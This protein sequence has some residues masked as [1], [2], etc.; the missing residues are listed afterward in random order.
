MNK[1]RLGDVAEVILSNIDKK[2]V[3]GQAK[4]RLCNFT[5]VYYNW[6]ITQE[7]HES[8][9]KATATNSQIDSLSISKGMVAITKDSETKYDIG[10]SVYIADDFDDVVLGYHCVLIKPNKDLLSGKY[11]NVILHSSYAQ[12]YFENHASGSG[13]RYTL[14]KE[15]IEDMKIPYVAPE[16][17]NKI[18]NFFSEIDRKIEINKQINDNLEQQVA[19]IY[20]YWFTQFDFPNDDGE[21]Y[22]SS[23][24]QMVWNDTLKKNIPEGWKIQS[25]TSNRLAS[26]I[27]PGIEVFDTKIYLATAD[28]KGT[29]LSVGTIID[30]VG[31]ESRA[32][33]Q[34]SVNSVWFAK[35]KNSIKH[36]NLNKEM[37]PVI[38]NTILSTGFCGLQCSEESF[39]YIASYIANP[40]FEIHKDMLAHGATQEAINND[41]LTGVHIIVP[42]DAVLHAYHEITQP[43]YAQISKNICENQEL[44]KLRDWLL[45]MLMNGQATIEQ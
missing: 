35:M 16:D 45:P 12:K 30:Y 10:I 38:S 41:D 28:V 20:N 27:K 2:S 8:F 5:D 7:M 29:T 13:Q 25:V 11:L 33:M 26:I 39:E 36:L 18:G 3:D 19:T 37:Q 32:N 22:C 4:V 17:Q 1:V 42:S 21:P 44:I 31:R 24:G 15:A 6:A 14:S 34:P 43:I 23:G 40:Y 9:M